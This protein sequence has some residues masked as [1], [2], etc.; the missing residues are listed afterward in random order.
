MGSSARRVPWAFPIV[1][2]RA[3]PQDP[4]GVEESKKKPADL[5]E[6]SR[7]RKWIRHASARACVRRES[8][9]RRERAST[10]CRVRQGTVIPGGQE[11]P[12]SH[13]SFVEGSDRPP[14]IST[15]S[16]A[17]LAGVEASSMTGDE[18]SEHSRTRTFRGFIET[19][20]KPRRSIS[21][22]AIRRARRLAASSATSWRRRS[23]SR[24]TWSASKMICRI[25]ILRQ[26]SWSSRAIARTRG[27][28]AGLG[29]ACSW[30]FMALMWL[31]A[32]PP[33]EPTGPHSFPRNVSI[34]ATS[35]S[36][37]LPSSVRVPSVERS[38]LASDLRPR[39]A[40]QSARSAVTR[41][42]ASAR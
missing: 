38:A 9:R 39:P 28:A 29:E 8:R 40:R 14:R 10:A 31:R 36:T 11:L 2:Q 35:R 6:R 27:R 12:R 37:S 19:I 25:M 41:G 22:R 13:P 7:G 33:S 42:V 3:P 1:R 17:L 4:P 18:G 15:F 23:D 16:E 32:H 24:G 21:P 20:V 30:F 34:S 26:R 5:T